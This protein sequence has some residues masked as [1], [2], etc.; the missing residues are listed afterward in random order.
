MKVLLSILYFFL[1]GVG[2]VFYFVKRK[3]QLSLSDFVMLISTILFSFSGVANSYGTIFGYNKL[4]FTLYILYLAN[5]LIIPFGLIFGQRLRQKHT[6]NSYS[7]SVDDT[8]LYLLISFVIIYAIGYF[9]IIKGNIPLVMLISGK[10]VYSVAIARLQVTHNFTSYYNA[11]FFYNYR[12]IVFGY[13]T[14][15]LFSILYIKYLN[16]KRKYRVP[17][18]IFFAIVIFLQFYTTEKVPLIYLLIIIFIDYYYIRL[19]VLIPVANLSFSLKPVNENR[20]IRRRI[21]IFIIIVLF[22][23]VALYTG[24]MGLENF[25]YGFNSML[26]RAFVQQS[27]SVYLQKMTLDSSFGGCLFGKGVSLTLIDS[28]IGRKPVNLSREA[29]ASLYKDY[30]IDGGGGTG[31]SIGIFNLYADFGLPLSLIVLFLLVVLTAIIDRKMMYKI[32]VSSNKELSVGFYSMLTYTFVQGYL[33]HYQSFFQLPFIIAPE[34][35]MVLV[36]TFLLRAVKILRVRSFAKE[37]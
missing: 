27:S 11:P 26:T 33:G 17:F 2:I 8:F 31:G 15:Y 4:D 24:F 36:L 7:G 13:L 21:I 19:R 9:V 16:N 35:L 3:K 29:Y 37:N 5:A 30:V 20:K 1:A 22:L 12:T 14:L 23:F 34:L 6:I 18:W 25:S 28:L 32:E 10:D